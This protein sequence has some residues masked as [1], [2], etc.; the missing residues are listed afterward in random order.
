MIDQENYLLELDKLAFPTVNYHQEIGYGLS[1]VNFFALAMGLFMFAAP[2]MGWIGYE[3]PTLGTAFMFGGIC[4]YLIGFYDWYRG[5]TMLS[6]V[7]F[8]FGI[9]HLVYY[10]VADIA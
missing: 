1:S 8:I 6:F 5:S 7:D 4:E 2:M 9:L 10:Y 3:S